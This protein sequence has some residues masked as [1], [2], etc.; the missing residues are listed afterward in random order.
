MWN[1]GIVAARGDVEG[2]AEGL[3]MDDVVHVGRSWFRMTSAVATSSDDAAVVVRSMPVSKT[4]RLGEIVVVPP[5]DMTARSLFENAFDKSSPEDE[6]IA[7]RPRRTVTVSL[8]GLATLGAALL[9]TGA[10]V[11]VVMLRPQAAPIAA[12]VVAAPAVAAPVVA[13]PVASAPAP[14]SA[15]APA[16]APAAAAIVE[17]VADEPPAPPPIEAVAAEPTAPV[18]RPSLVRK[19][20]VPVLTPVRRLRPAAPLKADTAATVPDPFA[21]PPAKKAWVDPFAD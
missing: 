20:P 4:A 15:P 9:F 1:E 17:P 2:L 21:P 5:D 13:A 6:L 12:P 8:W 7:A 16:P 11:A 19:A 3:V 18:A 14:V 10:A